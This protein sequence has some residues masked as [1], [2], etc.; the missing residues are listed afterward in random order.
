[1]MIW[2]VPESGYPTLGLPEFGTQFVGIAAA[3]DVL[4]MLAETE[5]TALSADPNDGI[6]TVPEFAFFRL[7]TDRLFA[8][9]VEL[10]GARNVFV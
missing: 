10:D 1:M 4:G 6:S 5:A 9:A 8:A 7:A 3:D 2:L